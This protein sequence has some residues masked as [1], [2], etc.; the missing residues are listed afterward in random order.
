M[1][2]ETREIIDGALAMRRRNHERGVRANLARHFAPCRFDGRD[3]IC[4]GSVLD[5][6]W[7]V[8]GRL[9]RMDALWNWRTMLKS[10]ASAKKVVVLKMRPC[11]V[12]LR[13]GGVGAVTLMTGCMLVSWGK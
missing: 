4:Q 1:R 10:D 13:S 3:G 5:P 8:Y 9:R 11:T 12:G 2:L 7:D 6:V